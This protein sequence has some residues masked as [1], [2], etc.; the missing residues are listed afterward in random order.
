MRLLIYGANFPPEE[1]GIGKYTGEMVAWLAARGHEVRVVMAPPFYPAWKVFDGYSAVR[2]SVERWH[3]V[4]V[5][6]CPLWVPSRQSGFKRLFHLVSFALCS[7]P[8]MLMQ[9]FWRPDVTMLIAPPL[10]CAPASAAVSW[11][12]GS[13]SWLHVQDFEVDAAF[14][15]GL[16]RHPAL[17]WLALGIERLLMKRFD[18]VSTIS[19]AMLAKLHVKGISSERTVHFPNWVDTDFIRPLNGEN[20]L[21]D[22]IRIPRN[23]IVALYSGNMGEKQGLDIVIDAA[24]ILRGVPGLWFVLCGDGAA[25]MRLVESAS[26]LSNVHWIPLQ[27]LERLNELLNMADIHLLPQLAGVEDSVMPSKLTGMLS[28]GRPVI[29]TASEVSQLGI[30]VMGRGLVVPP[31]DA[32]A[33]ALAIRRLAD[34]P[35]LRSR[36]GKEGR[37][38]AVEKL[39]KDGVLKRLEQALLLSARPRVR[40]PRG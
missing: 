22:E 29:A 3:D 27:P 16:L 17:K 21:K 18:R 13:V 37:R 30:V 35:A 34:D 15:T 40:K 26:G 33:M 5:W 11:L 7:G 4:R 9:S 20:T 14:E 36:L 2:Y 1:I 8:V 6:R 10:F 19:D 32:G 23:T 28:S 25:R 24:R 39:G 12:S 38:Y 31:G